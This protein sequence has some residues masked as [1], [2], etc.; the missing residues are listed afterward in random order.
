MEL[1]VDAEEDDTA[2]ELSTDCDGFES[3]GRRRID[4]TELRA[5]CIEEFVAASN[6]TER[7]SLEHRGTRTFLVL[8]E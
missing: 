8:E 2:A 5:D 7:V 3:A 1:I 4:V 6:S